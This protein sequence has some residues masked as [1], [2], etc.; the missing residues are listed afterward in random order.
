MTRLLVLFIAGAAV[1][2][3]AT[4]PT[5]IRNKA[6]ATRVF[7]EI[8]NQGKIQVADEI[9]APD[10][11]NHGLHR[12]FDLKADQDAVTPRSTRFPTSG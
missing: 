6:V 8:F 10:F 2:A 9:Y 11:R 4:T 12:D 7:E 5:E 3:R 1:S